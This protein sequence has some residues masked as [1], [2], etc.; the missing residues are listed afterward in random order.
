MCKKENERKIVH[1]TVEHFNLEI[2]NGQ[3]GEKNNQRRR[4][5][6]HFLW[7]TT[8]IHVVEMTND[9]Q[10]DDDN[11]AMPLN[12]RKADRTEMKYI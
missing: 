11:N 10:C 3:N 8:I 5:R 4:V 1:K 9:K 6:N 2:N 12:I 7:C